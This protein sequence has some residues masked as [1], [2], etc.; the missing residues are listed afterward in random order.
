MVGK[1]F[2]ISGPSGVGKGT[3]VKALFARHKEYC[4]SVS[5]TSRAPRHGEV[6]GKDYYFL[7]RVAFEKKIAQG[8]FLEWAEVHGNLYG[9]LRSELT[10]L[11]SKKQTVI[12]EI[13]VQGALNIKKSAIPST[14]I[15]LLPPSWEE[16]AKR[17]SG[18]GSENADT[19]AVRLQTAHRELEQQ[20]LYDQS[21]VN[22]TIP[23]TVGQ[24][25]KIIKKSI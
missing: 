22:N 12:L 11:L 19:L 23:D 6:E 20:N 25:E 9:T 15:F 7:D 13:D 2:V 1:L 21:I 17:L 4:W 14:L 5:C 16:L 3:I 10:R 24:I 8:E 18:R